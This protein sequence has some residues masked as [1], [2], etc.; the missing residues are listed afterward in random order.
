MVLAT[1]L[2][3]EMLHY[4]P[5]VPIVMAASIDPVGMGIVSSLARPGWKVTGF[6][7]QVAPEIEAKR[8][9]FLK[10]IAPKTSRVAYL[11]G[12]GE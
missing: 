4:A 6:A 5:R 9:H 1:P 11:A 2:A 3:K 7:N 8:L 10:E 12:K